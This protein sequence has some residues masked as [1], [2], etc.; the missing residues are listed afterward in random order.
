MDNQ[1]MLY[2]IIGC[3]GAILMGASLLLAYECSNLAWPSIIIGI[4]CVIL[5]FGL[6]SNYSMQQSKQQEEITNET[7]NK[8]E[9]LAEEANYTV[10][11]DGVTVSIDSVD[12]TDYKIII[13]NENKQI[14]LTH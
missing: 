14:I 1:I 3:V 12:L 7:I 8:A 9:T 6:G 2:F 4:L 11:L 13:D 10:Y 5:S